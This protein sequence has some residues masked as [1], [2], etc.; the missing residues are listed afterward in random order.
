MPDGKWKDYTVVEYIN[1][2]VFCRLGPS[3]IHGVGVFAIRDILKGTMF[4]DHNIHYM[5]HHVYGV[6]ESEFQKIFP[7][8]RGLILDRMSYEADDVELV[9]NSPNSDQFL[10]A[11]MNHA[12]DANTDGHYTLRDIKAGEELTEN[13][14]TLTQQKRHH[15]NI[16]HDKTVG[17]PNLD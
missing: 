6:P 3:P 13:F 16:E 5:N 9:F 15:L 4:T 8:I 10:Q 1:E 12:D 17:M 7:E 14:R 11:F 2:T